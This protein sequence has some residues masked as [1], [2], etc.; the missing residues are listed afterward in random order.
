MKPH[1]LSIGAIDLIFFADGSSTLSEDGLANT[2]KLS[3]EAA[4][5]AFES[6]PLSYRMSST[7][8][9][10][11]SDG[12]HILIDTGIGEGQLPDDG[13]LLADLA[14]EGITPDQIDTVIITHLHFDHFGGLRRADESATFPNAHV[15]VAQEDWTY[16]VE[17]GKAPA[18]RVELIKAVFSQYE[19]RVHFYRS[20]QTLAPGITAQALPGH[21]PG[22]H[23]MLIESNGKRALHI[24]DTLHVMMQMQNPDLSPIYDIDPVQSAHTRRVI[25]ERAANEHLLIF[26]YHLPFPGIGYVARKG[27]A[28]VWQE[29]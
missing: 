5:M 6:L 15:Y 12:R 1:H 4:L 29:V 11:R 22:H 24:V 23:G 3:P 14:A 10:V 13:H 21:T 16:W 8:I 27:E 26:M 7:P 9:Y 17:S 19:G 18:P 25:L 20:G 28:F 2:F